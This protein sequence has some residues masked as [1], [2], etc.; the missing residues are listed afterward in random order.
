MHIRLLPRLLTLGLAMLTP[1]VAR[2]EQPSDSL[3]WTPQ[4]RL[5]IQSTVM[6]ANGCYSA[7]V[8][9]TGAPQGERPIR[10]ALLVTFPLEHSGQSGCTMAVKP[11]RF[12][13]TAEVPEGAQAVIVYVTDRNRN[14]VAARAFA[15]PPRRE[16][17]A[18]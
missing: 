14:S 6:A 5:R 16:V 17:N 18:P 1:L 11:I 8:A 2:A 13:L 9:G 3:V 12:S 4:G 7:G 10:D 15:I